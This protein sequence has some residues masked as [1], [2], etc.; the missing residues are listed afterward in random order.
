MTI[1][2][3]E[4]RKLIKYI[5]TKPLENK[6]ILVTG[7]SGL[8]GNYFSS[9][10][11]EILKSSS[12][13]FELYLS[14]KSGEFN[15]I[16][17]KSTK[18]IIGDLCDYSKISELPEFDLIIHAAGYAQPSKFLGDA[19][20]TIK[21]NTEVTYALIQKVKVGGRF[22]YFSSSEVYSNLSNPPF[23][24]TQIGMSNTDHPRAAY[25]ESKRLGETIVHLANKDRKIVANSVRLALA[26][27]PG[28]KQDDSRVMTSIIR[29]ALEN[30]EIRLMDH[31]TAWRTYCYILDVVEM[32]YAVLLHGTGQVY[33]IGG[34]S[35]VQIKD[36]AEKVGLE[37]NSIV[38]YPKDELL[39]LKGAPVD[40]SLDLERILGLCGPKKFVDFD[41]GLRRTI[42]WQRS[43]I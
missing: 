17:D 31:G 30:K 27:G 39:T 28:A 32:A 18:I 4:V 11:Q 20:N 35:R 29:Q 9:L 21:I 1:I 23:R 6:K 43:Q 7:A 5:E 34:I 25:I 15:L 13:E 33:N 36:V 19:R 26:Y 41:D 2:N 12:A 38:V 14:S 16:I 22:L 3:S 42:E 10:F 37:T 24:E 40:V 8:V